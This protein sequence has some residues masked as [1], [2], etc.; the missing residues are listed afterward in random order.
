M[1]TKNTLVWA[2]LV[3]ASVFCALLVL[4]MFRHLKAMEADFNNKKS[5]LI[6]ENMDLKDEVDS[7]KSELTERAEA[8]VML[9]EENEALK[10]KYSEEFEGLRQENVSLKER[11]EEMSQRPFIEE[12]RSAMLRE[13]NPVMRK[14]LEK[15][16]Y[17]TTL[18]KS[19]KNIE[20]EPIVVAGEGRGRKMDKTIEFEEA[21]QGKPEDA[22]IAQ[23]GNRGE[24]MPERVYEKTV[25]AD[26]RLRS[27]TG[28]TGAVLTVDPKY[29]LAVINLGREDGVAENLP[30]AI[31]ENDKVKA[32]GEIISVRYKVSAAFL[33]EFSY[34]YSI[35]N[36][37]E[38]DEAVITR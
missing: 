17:N 14:F 35:K 12:V 6:R 24:V 23:S 37:K 31:V 7:I 18:I 22:E 3:S 25:P 26:M 32:R 30:V 19:G 5:S 13:Q 11:L 33:Q 28:K 27:A 29:S 16:L 9:Q 15:V 10:V 34:N 36:I 1:Q 38:G 21:V 2:I 8:M 20:L 4:F